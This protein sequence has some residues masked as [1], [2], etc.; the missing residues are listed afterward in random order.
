[1]THKLNTLSTWGILFLLMFGL[2]A[3]GCSDDDDP[4]G[5]TATEFDVL[6][7]AI[8]GYVSDATQGPV[9][10]A[11][12]LFDNV[13]DGN[14]ANDYFILSVRSAEHY[15][16]G[17][18]EGAINIPWREIGKTANLAL[19]PTDQPIAVYCYTGHTAGIAT[20]LL[21]TMGFEAY[22][23]K[24]GMGSWTKDQA[25]RVAAAFNDANDA[26]DFPFEIQMNTPT[27]TFDIP[28]TNYTSE[29]DA[30]AIMHAACDYVATNIPAT[31][32]AQAVFDNLND[33][34]AA[35]DPVIVSVRSADHYAVG[36]LPGA[37]NIPWREIALESNLQKLDPS[38]EIVVYCYTGHTGAVATTALRLLGY[39][40]V[41]MKFGIM[42]WT[43]DASVRVSAAFSETADAHDFPV[44]AG[45]NP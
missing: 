7:P 23:L 37:I 28:A 34:N 42:A 36:H 22:N 10:T 29:T 1:M 2:L 9:I 5:P 39:D 25:V 17:H 18:I 38:K 11:Q 41:N 8:H 27:A 14:A 24:F 20:A 3:F 30:D 21:N 33:G 13:N 45:S 6:Q 31:T 12:A 32:T 16:L 40:A 44:K 19:L 26:H 43:R 4:A 35:N 15:A